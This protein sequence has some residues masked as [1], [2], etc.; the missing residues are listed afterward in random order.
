M[1]TRQKIILLLFL[2]FFINKASAQNCT[3][4]ISDKI[5]FFKQNFKEELDLFL[6]LEFEI[7][8]VK[9]KANDTNNII[10]LTNKAE[11]DT[12]KYS[13]FYRGVIHNDQFICKLRANETYT[14]SPCTCCGIFLMTPSKNAERGYVKYV[15]NSKR[16]F[17]AETGELELDTILKKKKTDYILSSISMNCGFR[18]N[19]VFVA[20][21]GYLDKKFEYENLKSK[22]K[23]EQD[24]LNKEQQENI[25]FSFN[26][27]FLHKERLVVT[28]DET[29]ELFNLT[30]E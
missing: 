2:S 28:I 26:Y 21:F 18:P 10:V 22:P 24:L 5:D 25:R 7:N 13:F 1:R 20:D 30:I 17:I 16:D 4:K 9:I 12:I 29:G 23:E 19:T 15:N 3:V 11:F 6:S 14:I 8:N 27:L